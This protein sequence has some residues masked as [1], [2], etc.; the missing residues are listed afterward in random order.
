M[1]FWIFLAVASVLSYFSLRYIHILLSLGASVAWLA[2]WR[3]NL[4]YPPTNVVVGDI[5]HTWMTYVFVI[6]AIAVM[7][8][9]FRE[10]GRTESVTRAALGKEEVII[11][12]TKREGVT[13]KNLMG[14]TE[15]EY[16]ASVRRSLRRRRR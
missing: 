2:L 13:G 7:F 15:E 3:Y 8:M 5:T 12:T 4:V 16:K 6:V 1:T 9:W 14:L 11:Q 10:R